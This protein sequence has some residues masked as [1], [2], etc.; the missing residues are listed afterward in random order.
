MVIQW[1]PSSL[2]LLKTSRQS[3]RPP[4][5]ASTPLDRSEC[6]RG[7]GAS[8][9]IRWIDL[10]V[11]WMMAGCNAPFIWFC[12]CKYSLT[13]N[14]TTVRLFIRDFDNDEKSHLHY[15]AAD[16]R[17]INYVKAFIYPYLRLILV[18]SNYLSERVSFLV[19]PQYYHCMTIVGYKGVCNEAWYSF[20]LC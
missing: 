2:R 13:R 9:M 5:R 7:Y 4:V 3:I 8:K 15:K 11:L 6:Y 20:R 1:M 10:W 17:P 14:Q 19:V 16:V 12:E 18:C